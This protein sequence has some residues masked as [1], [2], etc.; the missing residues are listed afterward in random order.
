MGM[1]RLHVFAI[2]QRFSAPNARGSGFDCLNQRPSKK[3]LL[4]FLLLTLLLSACSTPTSPPMYTPRPSGTPTDTPAP[5]ATATATITLT[6]TITPTRTATPTITPTPT[7]T[8]TLIPAGIGTPLPLGNDQIIETTLSRMRVL[9]QW[10]RGR[11]EGLAW[12][13]DAQ[14]VAVATPLGVYL[15]N[16]LDLSTPLWLDTHAPAY[17]LAWAPDGLTLAVDTA[18]PG[19]GADTLIPLHQVQIWSTA[20]AG[21]T[22]LAKF[23]TGA[24]ALAIAYRSDTELGLLLRTAKGAAFQRW[25]VPNRTRLETINLNADSAPNGGTAAPDGSGTATPGSATVG[26]GSASEGALSPDFS[27]AATH[28]QA[29]TIRIWRLS[30]G[31]NLASTPA[32]DAPAGALAFSPDGK[33]LGA[34]YPDQTRDLQNSNL[35]RVWRVPDQPGELT[36]PTYSLNDPT[37]PEG[38]DEALISLAWSVDGQFVA[39]GASNQMV[40]LWR[41]AAGPVYRQITSGAMP[42][43]LAFGLRVGEGGSRL[44]I[45]GLEIWQISNPGPGA[46]VSRIGADENYLP[47]LFDMQFTPNSSLLT[48]AE[49]GAIDFRSVIDGHHALTIGDIAGAVYG[50]SFSPEGNYLAA[51]CQDGTTRLYLTRNGRYLDTLGEATY[52]VHSVAFS[53]HGF[54]IASSGEDMR[55]RIFRL[56][57][58]VQIAG[59]TE[60]FVAYKL[61]FSPNSD[62]LAS[63]TTQGVNL[64]K[65]TGTE[66]QASFDLEGNVGGVGLSDMVY[67]PGQEYLAL[68]GSGLVRVIEPGTRK[69]LYTIGAPLSGPIP[70]SVAFSPD[71]AFLAVGWSDGQIRFYWAQDGE[72][73]GT[74]Q[75]HPEAIQRLSFAKDGTLLAT[76]GQEGTIRIWGIGQ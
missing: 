54:W 70:W 36:L 6:P 9:S 62:Q 33:S 13:P 58:G 39:A 1:R 12:S 18:S 14:R 72:L 41:S 49:Y 71:N 35:V 74:W 51:A 68:V 30:D 59:F 24:Q 46:V 56:D 5:T 66:R 69:T 28:G 17:R 31:K 7:P 20:S 11:V 67:S 57:D 10:G 55:I 15:Y 50:V 19:S 21:D 60:P 2:L 32:S 8:P 45:G 40:H 64:R 27:H 3:L 22:P 42:R 43:F 4:A 26:N 73:K 25:D 63:L 48:L 76:Q 47:A 29:G 53:S 52:P 16:I 37:L 44:A 65:I 38:A 75:A 34:A 23:D 61:L